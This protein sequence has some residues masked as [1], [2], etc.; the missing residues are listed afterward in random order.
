MKDPLLLQSV[1]F[2]V[3]IVLSNLTPA[4]A[5]PLLVDEGMP[6]AQ[7]VIAE[8]ASRMTALAAGELQT[9][10]E[11][12]SGAHLPIVST[13]TDEYPLRIYVGRSSYTNAL[14]IDD[15]GLDYGAFIMR[16]VP[17]GLV[18]LGQDDDF[19]PT[20]PFT[21]QRSPNHPEMETMWAEWDEVSG[22]T[23]GNPRGALGRRYNSELGI[24]TYDQRGSLNA[25]HEFLRGLGVRWYMPGELGTII[26]TM[27]SVPLPEVDED[28]RPAF[29][30]RMATFAVYFSSPSDDI[31]YYLRQGFNHGDVVGH[32]S[33]GLRD[34][35]ARSEMKENHPERYALVRGVRMTDTALG[36]GN[37]A[38]LSDEG[39]FDA[40]VRFS[41]LMFD[42]YDLPM[43][44]MMPQDGFMFCECVLCEGQD[45]PERG[46]DGLH[47]DYVW[48]FV[49][50]VARELYKTHPD[51]MV[52]GLAYGT[53]RLPPEKID[54]LSPN[55][56]VGIVHSRGRNF[57]DPE[58]R[59][60]LLA[61]RKQWREKTDAPFWNWEHYLWSDR[62]PFVPFYYP[63]A[64]AR[65]IESVRDDYFGE[66]IEVSTG[67]F[68]EIGHGMHAPGVN[69]LNVYVTGRLH[70]DPDLDIN[71]LLEEYYELFY[72]PAAA[73]MRAFIEYCEANR[74]ELRRDVD[75]I[76]QAFDYL[77]TAVVAA[78][79]GTDYAA[80]IALV[81]DYMQGLGEWREQLVRGR[82]DVPVT[83]APARPGAEIE[84]DGRLDEAVWQDLPEHPLVDV[85]TGEPART[86]SWFKV[87]WDGGEREGHLVVGIYCREPDMDNVR[88]PTTE[89]GDWRIF[90]GDNVEVMVETQVHSYYQIAVNAAGAVVDL[91]RTF[92]HQNLDWTSLA[93]VATHQGENYWSVEMRIPVTGEETPGDPLHEVAGW[94]PTAD[95]PWHIQVGRQRL[96]GEDREWTTWSETGSNFHDLMRFGRLE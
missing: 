22:D 86:P 58:T 37:Q 54:R 65:G 6:R 50:R 66:F 46:R 74:Q 95:A 62:P 3:A 34:V 75:K 2:G 84:L 38:C 72:G 30:W 67:P 15:E 45:T 57:D 48:G 82:E 52:N 28:I 92:G 9:H 44:S 10:L 60:N 8:D 20:E 91:D 33:H 49:D 16:T 68:D 63:Q 31:L 21:L 88:T 69:H 19:V 61:L 7:I 39:L 1:V 41:R 23:F 77:D 36:H 51:R 13:P 26:P 83:Q 93:Q 53:Y 29:D 43:V 70:W 85:R 87:F 71:A 47:S 79:E 81:T 27:E 18:L 59:E 64:I 96:R 12:I 78:P 11:K 55:V 40:A 42:H 17:D 73:E 14:G 89:S 90:D 35:T 56:S 32:W 4:S 94:Q 5:A 24:H 80:R 25:V 76:N